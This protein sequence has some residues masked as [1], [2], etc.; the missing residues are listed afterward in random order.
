MVERVPHWLTPDHFTLLGL[1]G[2]LAAAAGYIASQWS[3]QWLWFAS[4]GLL[5]HWLGDSLDGTLARARRIE[6]HRYGFFV[7]HSSDLFSQSL[8]F[9]SLG[10]SPCTRLP[11]AMAGL[12][13]FL[14]AFV[15]TLICAEVRKT[16]RIT[17][18]GFGPT[19]IRVLLIAGNCIT[20]VAGVLDVSRWCL[21]APPS[22]LGIVTLYDVVILALVALLVPSL[23]WLALREARNLASDDPSPDGDLL[24]RRGALQADI[25]GSGRIAASKVQPVGSPA[26]AG[27]PLLLDIS[28]LIW[29]GRRRSPTG[30]DRVELAYALHFVGGGSERPVYAVLHLF[31]LLFAVSP[32]AGR[33]FIES[34][35][36]RW[37]GDE[38]LGRGERLRAL[39][40]TY[41]NLLC[42]WYLGPWLRHELR[43]HRGQPIFLVVSHHHIGRGYTIE[44]LRQSLKVRTVCLIHDLIP[45]E[46]PEYLP[47]G[48]EHRFQRISQSIASLF[49]AVIAN[50]AA[51]AHAVRGCL[52]E[53]GDLAPRPQVLCAALGAST[54]PGA[55]KSRRRLPLRPYFAVV[56]TIEPRKNHLLLLNLWTRLVNEMAT[57]PRLLVIGA[58]GWENEQVV[59]M[60]ER[61]RR[62]RGVVEEHGSL[63][64]VEVGVMLA[65]ARALLLPS[66]AE[67][68]GLPLAEALVSGVPAICSDIPPFREL[69]GDVPEYLD[70]LDL[71]AWKE[72][73]ME[74]CHPGSHRRAAQLRRLK[75]WRAPSWRDHFSQVEQLLT[76]VEAGRG[77][78]LPTMAATSRPRVVGA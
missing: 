40:K 36:A 63:S 78:D 72:A 8:I 59:D 69:G 17:Y 6:R 60:L 70:P 2:S 33:R 43:K 4:L 47:P 57:P 14:M 49:D 39:L 75:G 1:F 11:I 35:A 50:S 66:F 21:A 20:A 68:F 67:G 5:L 64:D 27:S 28:R 34:L 65:D 77:R 62:L 18:F 15:Y 16:M 53:P 73:V 22:W 51:T 31:G 45:L 7:D 41:A 38:Q 32:T 30:I 10:L 52:K 71:R 13:A 58:R 26:A 9:L 76:D 44:R 42:I 37:R 24:S 74:Y 3:L 54:F 29:R 48:W 23:A 12:I 55:E 56:G 46:Y 19:E 61:S 25:A